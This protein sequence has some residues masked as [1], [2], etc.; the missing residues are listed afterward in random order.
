MM[1]ELA[2]NSRVYSFLPSMKN[3]QPST[4]CDIPLVFRKGTNG[5]IIVPSSEF[6][7]VFR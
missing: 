4:A 5:N 2:D 6:Y 3:Y 1:V 7:L